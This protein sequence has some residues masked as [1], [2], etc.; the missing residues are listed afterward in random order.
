MVA[1]EET[2]LATIVAPS[3]TK[4]GVA[5]STI[6]EPSFVLLSNFGPKPCASYPDRN[7]YTWSRAVVA[8]A[9]AL[10]TASGAAANSATDSAAD[11]RARLCARLPIISATWK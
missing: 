11:V 3:A 2:G 5:R 7:K 10:A 4:N 9:T 8:I 1:A 6:K